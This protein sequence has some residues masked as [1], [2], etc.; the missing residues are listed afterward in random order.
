MPASNYAYYSRTRR[1]HVVCDVRIDFMTLCW[2]LRSRMSARLF[3]YV[4][5]HELRGWSISKSLLRAPTL[6]S[7]ATYA[8]KP[9]VNTPPPPRMHSQSR[10]SQLIIS[11]PHTTLYSADPG[12]HPSCRPVADCWDSQLKPPRDTTRGHNWKLRLWSI[13]ATHSLALAQRTPTDIVKFPLST[14]YLCSY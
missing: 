2:L 12:D 7:V 11:P 13:I 9:T 8:A 10:V 6:P 14:V 3:V 1:A 5:S 4:I